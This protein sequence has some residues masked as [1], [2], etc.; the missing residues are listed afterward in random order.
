MPEEIFDIYTLFG[1]VPPRGGDEG[2]DRLRAL[3]DRH[4]VRAAATVSTHAL[5]HDALLGN[6][7]TRDACAAA[8]GVA[9]TSDALVCPIELGLRHPLEVEVYGE[10]N[11]LARHG[12]HHRLGDLLSVM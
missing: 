5:Y 8:P 4:G 7:E 6:R 9:G 10:R 3:L 2:T 12:I 1:P 11:V